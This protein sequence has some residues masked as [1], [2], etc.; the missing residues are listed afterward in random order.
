MS[1]DICTIL[2]Y[3]FHDNFGFFSF[4]W[5]KIIETE[6]ERERIRR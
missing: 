5:S 6:K 4:D 3:N 2:W 1:N